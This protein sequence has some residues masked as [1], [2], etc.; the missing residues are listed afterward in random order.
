MSRLQIH[1]IGAVLCLLAT[2]SLCPLPASDGNW[3][4]TP[5]SAPFYTPSGA[6]YYTPPRSPF[7]TPPANTYGQPYFAPFETLRP[8]GISK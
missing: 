6:P 2:V 4:Y 1:S 7:Y 8:I 5:P 3:Y